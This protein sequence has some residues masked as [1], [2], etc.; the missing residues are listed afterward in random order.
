MILIDNSQVILSSIFGQIKGNADLI[1]ESLVRHITLNSYRYFR[2][3]FG[4][5]F[6]ELVICDDSSNCWRKDFFPFYKANRKKSQEK[7]GQDWSAIYDTLTTIRNEIIETF[8][9]KNMRVERCEADDIIAVLCKNMHMQEKIMIVSGDKDFKQLQMY[10]NVYQYS[11]IQRTMLDCDDPESFLFEH[12]VKGDSS[13]GIP[14]ILS[15]DDV[16]VNEDKRQK[17]CGAKKIS[18][19]REDRET[20]ESTRNWARNKMLIDLSEIPEEVEDRIMQH[21][22]YEPIVGSRSKIFNYFVE[23]KLKNLMGDIQEF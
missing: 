19:L 1:D 23:H 2:N 16:F 4:E 7:S 9:Y 8:P 10:P 5:E 13:D 22:Y 18:S 21:W 3:R 20:V 6:G 11:P 14:N 17:P 12:I 15:D